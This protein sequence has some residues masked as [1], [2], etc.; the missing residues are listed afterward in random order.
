MV[1]H[2]EFKM[3]VGGDAALQKLHESTAELGGVRMGRLFGTIGVTVLIAS[4]IA[5][6]SAAIFR[7][8]SGSSILYSKWICSMRRPSSSSRL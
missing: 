3:H 5:V 8:P 1:W 7:T 2:R 6:W 4:T